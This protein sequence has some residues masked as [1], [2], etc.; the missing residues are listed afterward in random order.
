MEQNMKIIGKTWKNCESH[1]TTRRKY[2][3]KRRNNINIL[4]Q[5]REKGGHSMTHL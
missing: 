2:E 1:R 4:E 3:Q 5:V